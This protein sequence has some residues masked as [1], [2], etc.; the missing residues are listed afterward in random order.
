MGFSQTLDQSN[1]SSGVTGGAFILN[2]SENVQQ[3]FTAGLSGDLTQVNIQVG[4]WGNAFVAGDFQL[5][6]LNGNGSGGAVLNTTIFSINTSPTTNNYDEIN[7][8]LSSTVPIT[9][10][11]CIPLI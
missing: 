9:G 5:R 8:T 6:I 7:I 4:N 3:S 10:G 2:S 11:T 1:A